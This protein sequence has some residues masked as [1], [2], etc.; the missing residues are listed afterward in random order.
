M[1]TTIPEI[2][3]LMHD[4]LDTYAAQ[5][6]RSTG[7]VRRAS[8]LT[9]PLFAQTLVFGWWSHPAATLDELTETAALLG[10]DLSPQALQAR[11]TPAAATFLQGLLARALAQSTSAA[12]VALPLLQRF[13][14]VVVADGT[15]ITLPASL[16]AVWP[17]CGNGTGP[18]A[19]L[20]IVAELDLVRGGLTGVLTAGRVADRTAALALPPR[21][22]GCLRLRDLG[23]FDTQVLA[24]WTAAG[25][26]WLSRVPL[27]VGIGTAD[28]TPLDL[29]LWLP[30]QAEERGECAIRLGYAAQV[31]ARLIWERVPPVVAEA[32]QVALIE[33][34]V[35][36]GRPVSAQA[37]GLTRWTL[38]VTN[39]SGAELSV[40][41]ALVL[42]RA[43]WEIELLFKRW[44]SL[45]QVDE[46]RS[47]QPWRIL[48]EVYAK[49][50]GLV[51]QQRVVAA[52]CWAVAERS[53][54]RLQ[55]RVQHDGTCLAGAWGQRGRVVGV[56]R[57]LVRRLGKGGRI[58]KRAT[59]PALYQL[60]ADPA[61]LERKHAAVVT[62][63]TKAQEAAAAKKAAK[64]AGAVTPQPLAA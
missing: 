34:A 57:R 50:L 13:T 9:G 5:T 61:L 35:R 60:L 17:G 4:V 53:L 32:R 47:T 43:R 26:R 27:H 52:G 55:R 18:S 46:W 48:C 58:T 37:W 23:F 63:L 51:L 30:T 22:A 29:A 16:A 41:E 62:R 21:P 39:T 3:D 44:K 14:A 19:A 25:D 54:R 28:G 33:D 10:C 6:A 11:F 56:V 15:V 31:P 24:A 20:K 12:A 45:G 2:V 1:S 36:R 8:K 64:E 7:F 59:E 40:Q 38:L 49:L 42:A